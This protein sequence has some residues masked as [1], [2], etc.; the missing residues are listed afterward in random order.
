MCFSALQCVL[1]KLTFLLT[2]KCAC[3][4]A[5]HTGCDEPLSCPGGL[6]NVIITHRQSIVMFQSSTASPL[7]TKLLYIT[8]F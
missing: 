4:H 6:T 8:G 2:H 7:W 5:S 3:V 1:E